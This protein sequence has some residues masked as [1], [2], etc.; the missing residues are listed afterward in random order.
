MKNKTVLLAGLF[1]ETHSFLY[2]K[3]GLKEFCEGGISIGPDVISNNIGNGSPADG[4]LDYADTQEWSII[5]AIQMMANPSGIVM[6]EVIE[7]FYKHF[8]ESFEKHCADIDGIF[9]VLHGAMV[10]EGSDDVEGD[11]FREIHSRLTA[12]GINIPVVAVIDFHANV[13]KDMTD[14]STCL[15]S[16]RMNPHTDA[17]KAAV[18]AATLFGILMRGQKATQHHLGT[19]YVIPPTGLA[20]ASD[21]MKAVLTRARAI[22]LQD[23]DILCINVM[24]GYSYADIVDCGFSLN[25]C[26]S[27]VASVA[28]GY[29]DEL[30]LVFEANMSGAY[31]KEAT[32]EMVLKR[33]DTEPRG[34]GPIL[35]V[36]PADNIGGGT[37]GDGT[38]LLSPLLDSGRKNIIAILN[39][40]KAASQ[41]HTLKVGDQVSLLI[42]AKLDNH[43]GAPIK[44]DGTI[45]HLS[46][47]QFDLEN[48]NSH[49]ASMVG[50]HIDMGLCAVLRN[51]QVTILLTSRKT[52]PM[53]LGQLHSQGIRPENA[54]YVVVKAAVSHKDAYDPIAAASYNVESVGLCT[55]N[56]KALPYQKLVGKQLSG[57]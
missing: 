37:P 54:D 16:Y 17:R 4:F 29:L 56:L 49:L 38:G 28:Q 33:I 36:E 6:Q 39:D 20:T 46:D 35:L 31:P 10:S 23:P 42:G 15:Y 8:F 9:L 51:E 45:R 40:P 13:S 3:T 27:G 52:P 48:K 41:C 50:I 22:E 32:L 19:P 25:C 12:K 30:L 21:P 2:H 53:D 55:S 18:E 34:S 57:D 43:H 24:G 14:L 1:H 44:F 5:P 11:L 47:G 26:T 7:F